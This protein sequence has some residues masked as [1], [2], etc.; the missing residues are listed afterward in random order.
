M[1]PRI[2][3]GKYFNKINKKLLFKYVGDRTWKINN[4][5]YTYKLGLNDSNDSVKGLWFL[6]IHNLSYCKYFGNQLY[7]V[8]IPDTARVKQWSFDYETDKIIL[9]KVDDQIYEQILPENPFLLS[10]IKKTNN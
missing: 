9:K 10:Y 5:G 1:I 6:D 8:E 2:Y 4:L 3:T 7:E